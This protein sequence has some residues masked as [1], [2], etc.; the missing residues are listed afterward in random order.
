[1][2][3]AAAAV[4]PIATFS[5]K[6][7]DF[8][9]VAVGSSISRSV[10]LTNTG[11]RPLQVSRTTLLWADEVA[12]TDDSCAGRTLAPRQRCSV[13]LTYSPTKDGMLAP[14]PQLGFVDNAPGYGG[15]QVVELRG[16]TE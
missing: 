5:T 3:R 7:I 16:D 4:G 10:T 11:D 8:G 2:V 14:F 1:M 13:T 12:V 9:H 6:L 15:G